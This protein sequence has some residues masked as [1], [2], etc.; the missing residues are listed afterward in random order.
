MK[1][2]EY[3]EKLIKHLGVDGEFE[4]VLEETDDRLKIIITVPQSDAALLIGNRGETLESIELLTKLSFKD[5]FPDKRI[6]L[7]I[8]EYRSGLENRLKEKALELARE[9][10]KTGEP[11]EMY[12]LNSYERYLVHSVLAEDKGLVKIE[13]VSED[14]DEERVLLIKVKEV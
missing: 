1:V 5:D 2:Q 10:L 14:R 4:I 12:D 8:N 3:L 11:R 7:D 9:V 13:S 6:M